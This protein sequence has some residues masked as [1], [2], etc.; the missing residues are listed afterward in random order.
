MTHVVLASK[1]AIRAELLRNSGLI[2]EIQPANVDERA[3]EEPAM[4]KGA[5]PAEVAVI[6]AGE[7]ARAVSIVRPDAIVIGADQTLALGLERFSKPKDRAAARAH[8]MR[9]RGRTHVLASGAAIAIKGEVIWTGVQEA[10]MT[11]RPFSDEFLEE[12]LD[13]MGSVVT[14][15]VGGYQLEGLGIQLFER[16]EGD[17]FTI[18][19]LPLLALLGGMR[20]HE[21]LRD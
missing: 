11:M 6:L 18:L 8:L 19:G 17:T 12:Y 3:I 2:P 10:A 16:I 21:L 5:S 1:S 13:Q 15:T 14:T 4:A 9:L 20:A 7:K